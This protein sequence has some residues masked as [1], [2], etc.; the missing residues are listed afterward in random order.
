MSHSGLTLLTDS[1][2][3]SFKKYVMNIT[4]SVS[5]LEDIPHRQFVQYDKY[6]SHSLRNPGGLG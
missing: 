6:L 5:F 2:I 3:H 4:Y 1:L